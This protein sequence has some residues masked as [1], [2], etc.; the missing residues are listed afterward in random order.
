MVVIQV[1]L[2]IAVLLIGVRLLLSVGARTQALRRLLLI[3]LGVFAVLS[4]L[5]PDIWSQ[6]ARVVGVGRGTD[7]LL[8]AL[9]VAFFGFVTTSYVRFRDLEVRYTRLARRIALDEAP[10]PDGSGSPVI[11]IHPPGHADGPGTH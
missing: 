4:I 11:G 3:A 1:L 7:L 10:R 8:Y 9:V 5:L 2:I 6:L